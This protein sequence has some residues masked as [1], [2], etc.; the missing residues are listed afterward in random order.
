MDWIATW[1]AGTGT[2]AVGWSIVRELQQRRPQVSVSLRSGSW[3]D[4]DQASSWWI[5]VTI[6]N[7]GDRS[8]G[9]DW[10]KVYQTLPTG[11]EAMVGQ[12]LGDPMLTVGMFGHRPGER[13]AARD[14]VTVNF[15]KPLPPRFQ[16]DVPVV[17]WAELVTGERVC[18]RPHVLGSS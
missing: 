9:V 4:G 13:I 3:L 5:K 11:E 18:S 1:G 17:A 2:L 8:V 6:I 7:H 12:R 14:A 10:I 15:G 16:P